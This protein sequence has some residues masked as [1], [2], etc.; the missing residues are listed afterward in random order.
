MRLAGFSRRVFIGGAIFFRLRIR[1]TAHLVTPAS[2]A[3][4]ASGS[5]QLQVSHQ[6][7]Q[8]A[9]DDTPERVVGE[10]GHWAACVI[11]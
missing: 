6:A 2:R 4:T 7:E 11:A 1:Q 3:M 5:D 8:T 9:D 10:T